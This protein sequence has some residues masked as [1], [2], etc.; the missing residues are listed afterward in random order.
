MKNIP[1]LVAAILWACAATG[2]DLPTPI[3]DNLFAKPGIRNGSPGKGFSISYE[4]HPN[5]GL[6]GGI[7][8]EGKKGKSDVESK[9]RFETKLK[10]P[11]FLRCNWKI[12]GDVYYAFEKY[13]FETIQPPNNY[14]FEAI[15]G[16][17]LKRARFTLYAFRSISD[18]NYLG[19]RGE[20]SANGAYDGFVDF[21]RRYMIYRGAAIF[22]M[23]KSD[24][25][26]L[27]FGAM[28]S[29]SFDRLRAY[30]FMIF[31]HNFNEKW[32]LETVL[33]IKYSLRHNLS[34]KSLLSLSAEYWSSAYSLDLQPPNATVPQ[35]YVFRSS[36]AQVFL[37]WE[38]MLLTNWT[39]VSFRLG[40]SHNFD[41]RFVLEGTR[42]GGKID[43][44][45]SNSI[46]LTAAF[47]ISP[48]KQF[49]EAHSNKK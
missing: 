21:G 6:Q 3:V 4:R 25:N 12:L 10:I 41:S 5:Y 49:M 32:G 40:Y 20:V 33:P 28:V 23:K 47:F 27:G 13:R 38:K 26:E 16:E 8:N 15:D 17:A 29:H 24:D 31:N 9:E 42:D 37:E 36:A 35:P 46:F 18:K 45:P 44:F 39:W 22:G 19:F 11:I 7:L 34:E 1:I 48:P 14:A 43:A 2:Q 30:P